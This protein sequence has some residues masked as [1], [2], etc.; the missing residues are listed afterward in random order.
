V[1]VSNST[2]SGNSADFGDGGGIYNFGID[3]SGGTMTLTN[4]IISGN[5]APSDPS[6]NECRNAGTFIADANNIFGVNG[7]S[8][9]CPAGTGD[10]VPTGA[11]GTVLDT[12]LADNGGPT[13]THAL[14]SGSPAIDAADNAICSS[15]PVNNID[16][17][18]AL[19]GVD[20]I[21]T[22]DNPET[23]DCDIGAYEFG[24][25]VP[26]VSFSID[27]TTLTEGGTITQATVTLTAANILAETPEFDV[28]FAFTGDVTGDDY[29]TN[30]AAIAITSPT[31]QTFTIDIVDD[32]LT[33]G[34][35][36]LNLEMLISGAAGI[37]GSNSQSITFLD[38]PPPTEPPPADDSPQPQPTETTSALETVEELPQTG[39][40]PFWRD[41]LIALLVIGAGLATATGVVFR[42]QS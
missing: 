32:A 11:I 6:T 7:N 25:Q 1:T 27:E 41:W 20:G 35:E 39:E 34:A 19:R 36:T 38:A 9:E 14:V 15:A 30:Y 33:E 40:T 24:G 5:S 12:T 18:G 37:T 29:S 4:S 31:P 22:P 13:Q 28:L 42:R 2:V 10:I 3:N 26:T 17:R 23:G 21:G 16:Q 8:G